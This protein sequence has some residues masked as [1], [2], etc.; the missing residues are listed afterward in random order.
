[1]SFKKQADVV[2]VGSGAGG[3]PVALTLSEAG[4]KV[5]VLERGPWYTVREFTHDEV[6][7]C[8]RD[9]FVPYPYAG[10]DPKTIRKGGEQHAH[11]TPEGWTSVC[12]GGGTVHMSGFFYR[13]K[14]S[15]LRLKTMTGGI[16]GADLADWPIRMDDLLPF[17][18]LM[19]ARIGVS[20]QAGINPF[21]TR[22]R[23]FPLPPL[24]PHP[25]ARL[26]DQAATSLGFHP[27]PTPRAITSRSYGNR[28]P[29]NYC[30]F[31]GDYGCENGS[32]SSTLASLIPAAEDTGRCLIKPGCMARRVLVD[33]DDR[34]T[35][36][37][38]IDSQGEVRRIRARVVVLAATAIESARLLLL[39]KT[40][41]FPD[42]LGNR[43]GLLG[44]NLTFS[45]FG[46]GTAIFDRGEL[47]AKLG[48]EGMD[49]PFL[50]RSVQDDYWMEKTPLSLPKGGTYNFL[51]HHPNPINAA[52]RLAL[53]SKWS[54]WGQKLKDRI[55]EYFHDE[56]W[57]EFEVFGE[58]LPNQGCYLDL[59][60]QVKDHF[61]LPV[62]RITNRHHPVSDDV[63]RLM[64]RRGMDIFEA[65]KPAPKKVFPW[66]WATTTY[67][68][69]HGT[70]RFGTDPAKSVLDPWCQ[71]H[72]IKNLYVTDG[73]FLPNSGG[74]PVTATILANSFRVA[75]HLSGRFRRREI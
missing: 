68:L 63:N 42:G 41:R 36:V 11:P 1:M 46:K 75:H 49:L 37:E 32:K 19:E 15:D 4:A 12:V 66:T 34:V 44:K 24:R 23:P 53:D 74:V 5:V 65:M 64:V 52:V 25:A 43:S 40:G 3:A 48:K 27:F 47:E 21:E 39:S 45:T 29:C 6:A 18:D 22:R 60:P 56:L 35:G 7:I 28:P 20:G 9:F 17:Y 62:A 69:Q 26:L 59:D 31:C 14:E 58:F 50:L 61:N 72:D 51:L 70:C 67:H 57:M 30:G 55:H 71:S 10:Y 73:S 13:F 54:L 16:K 38:Y 2:V 8:R 33:K